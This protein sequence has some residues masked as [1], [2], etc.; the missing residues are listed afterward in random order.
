MRQE[1]LPVTVVVPVYNGED[2]IIS[3]LYSI[4]K[5]TVE[6]AEIIVCDNNSTDNTVKL[7]IDLS[8]KSQNLRIIQNERNIGYI[9]NLNRCLKECK[10]RFIR[11]LHVDDMLEKESIKEQFDYLSLNPN[12][13][14]IGGQE[15]H[16]YNDGRTRI[17]PELTSTLCF[18]KG[19]IYEF[20]TQIGHYIP[21]STVML[22]MEKIK[23]V[24]IFPLNSLAS[25]EYFWI[26]ILAMY[27][28]SVLANV[29]VLRRIHDKNLLKIWIIDKRKLFVKG[30]YDLLQIL[31]ETEKRQDLNKKLQKQKRKSYSLRFVGCAKTVINKKGDSKVAFWYLKESIKMDKNIIIQRVFWKSFFLIIFNIIG[32]YRTIYL[33]Y[34]RK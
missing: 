32:L 26:Q 34:K 20:A 11:I 2:F 5:Q 28:I 4:F 30:T 10:T 29:H 22:D 14:L 27:P 6:V 17:L 13:A 1:K 12:L 3:A 8:R 18:N 21:V 25:D 24:G 15:K 33:I 9:A 16:I 31:K 23:N 19:S 7:A